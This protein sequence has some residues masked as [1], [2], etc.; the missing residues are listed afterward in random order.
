MLKT[1]HCRRGSRYFRQS[2]HP[3][4][5]KVRALFLC[6]LFAGLCSF[7]TMAQDMGG[8][9][10]KPWENLEEA[11]FL[12]DVYYQVVKCNPVGS[13]EVHLWAFNEGGNVDAIGFTLTLKD[14]DGTEVTH[15]VERFTI[16]LG[17]SFKAACVND[18]Y[19]YLKF[20]LPADI[21]LASMSID[22]TY[23]K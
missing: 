11:E 17:E 1:L 12:F 5:K 21:D 22:I 15:N 8:E 10:L 7:Q 18:D 19:P 2:M 6:L 14:G 3:A 4:F 16:G 23:N 13:A 9:V 20:P